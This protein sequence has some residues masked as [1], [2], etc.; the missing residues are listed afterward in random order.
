[1]LK[2]ISDEE[3][4][5]YIFSGDP[6]VK[7]FY[8]RIPGHIRDAIIKRHTKIKKGIEI[9]DKDTAGKEFIE[10]ALLGWEGFESPESNKPFPFSIENFDRLPSKPVQEFTEVLIDGVDYVKS[11]EAEKNS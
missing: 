3:R 8:R 7:F 4:L 5:V 2:A 10:Y 6:D 9:Y 1:M 11:E